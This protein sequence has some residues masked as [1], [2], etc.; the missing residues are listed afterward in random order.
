MHQSIVTPTPTPPALSIKMKQMY[1][2][3]LRKTF[4]KSGNILYY[5]TPL[6]YLFLVRS[7]VVLSVSP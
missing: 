4:P 5:S 7:N 3:P 6:A 2:V 1:K